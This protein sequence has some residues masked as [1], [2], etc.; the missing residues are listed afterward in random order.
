[1]A[2]TQKSLRSAERA[3]LR[4]VALPPRL[5]SATYAVTLVLAAVAIY[6][7]VGLFVGKAHVLIDDLRYGR[8]RTTQLDAFVGHDEANGQPTHLM[9]INLNRQVTIVELPGGD[10]AKAR[11]LNGPYLFGADEN[12]TTPFIDLRDVDG[13]GNV[14]LILDIRDEQIIYLNKDGVFRLPKPEELSTLSRGGRQ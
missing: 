5:Y 9:A 11:S 2:I 12:L 4:G 3:R 14:D 10:A 13:D 7:V 8:P 1:M 6:V